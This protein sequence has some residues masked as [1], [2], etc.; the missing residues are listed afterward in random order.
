MATCGWTR[1]ICLWECRQAYSCRALCAAIMIVLG[2]AAYMLPLGLRKE[3]D[4]SMVHFEG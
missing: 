3:T 1:S 2:A 4:E